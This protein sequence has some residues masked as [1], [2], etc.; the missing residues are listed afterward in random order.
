MTDNNTD[1]D[2]SKQLDNVE[3]FSYLCIMKTNNARRTRKI[4]SRIAM[5]KAASNNKKILFTS[6]LDSN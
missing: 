6:K 1:Y 4:K 3:Y 2:R 5:A